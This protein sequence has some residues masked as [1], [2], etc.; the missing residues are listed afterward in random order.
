MDNRIRLGLQY[1]RYS[2]SSGTRH[3]VHSPFVFEL[4]EQVLRDKRNFYFF[5]RIEKRRR[6]LET[7]DRSI[8][9]TDFGAGSLHTGSRERKVSEI[10]RHAAKPPKYAQLLFRLVNYFQPG[11]VLELGTSLGVSTAY[12][13]AANR[14][15]QVVT[16]EGCPE[17]AKVATETFAALQLTNIELITG[18][19]DE[20]L[21]P[22]LQ[23]LPRLDFAFIDG[24]HRKEPTLRYFSQCLTKAHKD[25]VLIFDDIHW[26]KDM[27]AAWRQIQEHPQVTLTADLFFIG[28]VFFRDTFR[29]KQHFVLRY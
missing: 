25:T 28:L 16:M 11:F 23:A 14:Q 27:E 21:A 1:I 3:D 6:Q 4:I 5:N 22:V 10:A 13:A 17:T 7:D 24:N 8:R 19:F 9:V 12:L 18:N 20:T 15:A 29:E 26:T 2:L